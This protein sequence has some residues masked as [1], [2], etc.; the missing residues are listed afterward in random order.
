MV[1]NCT[2]KCDHMCGCMAVVSNTIRV[3]LRDLCTCEYDRLYK[4][5]PKY[6]LE[7]PEEQLEFDF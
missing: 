7:Y 3:P 1:C 5:D 4:I 6:V 2:G